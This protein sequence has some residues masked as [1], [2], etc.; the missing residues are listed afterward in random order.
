[1]RLRKTVLPALWWAVQ[2]QAAGAAPLGLPDMPR[3]PAAQVALGEALFFERGLSV[4]GTLSCAMCHLPEQG[5]TSNELRTS[6]GMEG[7]SLRRNAPT[8]LN[9]GYQRALFHDGRASTLEQQALMP[10]LHPDEM[11]NPNAAA[12]VKRAAR[13]PGYARLYRNAFGDARP[14]AR[15]IALALAAYQRTLLA[16]DS[17]FDRWHY[18]GDAL[19]MTAQAR[20]G[21]ELFRE[22]GCIRCHPVGAGGTIFSDHGF[23]NVG[24]AWRSAERRSQDTTVLLVPGLSARLKPQQLARI[25]GIDSPDDGRFEVTGQRKDLRAFRTPTLRDV[26]LTAPYMHDGSFDTLEQVIDH[27]AAGGSPDDPAQDPAIQPFSVSSN[28]RQ[29]LVRFLQALT[30]NP[31]RENLHRVR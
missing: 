28:D 24:T 1:M 19:A 12:L 2:A 23:H 10:L 30:S 5:F 13:L 9:V 6:V 11:A 27:Y 7:V 8:L 25:G 15:R 3:P 18:G 22:L 14:N 21:F 16:G 29:A 26:A 31:A 17:A 20:R 4:N